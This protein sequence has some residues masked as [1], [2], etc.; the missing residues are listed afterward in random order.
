[1]NA[2]PVTIAV[3]LCGWLVFIIIMNG[4]FEFALT[5]AGGWVG[6]KTTF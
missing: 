6:V 4:V 5:G 2:S 1:V 3:F